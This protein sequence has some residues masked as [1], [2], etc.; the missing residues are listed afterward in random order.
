MMLRLLFTYLASLLFYTAAAQNY[1]HPPKERYVCEWNS[2]DS[3]GR[4]KDRITI[5][6]ITGLN[7]TEHPL[8]RSNELKLK[9]L[10]RVDT[11]IDNYDSTRTLVHYDYNNRVFLKE[12]TGWRVQANYLVSMVYDSL[13]RQI[14]FDAIDCKRCDIRERTVYDSKGNMVVRCV[15]SGCSGLRRLDI[16][17]DKQEISLPDHCHCDF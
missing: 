14:L 16:F 7:L 15:Y 6:T 9:N 8:V 12:I 17:R 2:S 1:I 4:L 5:Y 13:G 11:I 10:L 3:L